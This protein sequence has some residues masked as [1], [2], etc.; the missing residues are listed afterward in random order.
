MAGLEDGELPRLERA[1]ALARMGR[2][3]VEPNPPVGCVLVG[4]TGV[5]GEGWH[6]AYG[7][8]HAEV[9]ALRIAGDAA[10]G[11]TAFVSLEPC[12]RRGKTPP[13][14]EALVA[15]G[16]RRVVFAIE[17]PHPRQRGAGAQ[18]LK[19]AGVQVVGP[20]PE[21]A[22]AAEALLV[23]FRAALARRRPWVHLKWAMS[24]D[25]RIAAEAGRGGAISGARARALTHEWRG[26]SDAVAV[27]VNTVLAD[28][29]DLR[30]R[31]E[32]GP[33]DGRPQPRRVVFDTSLR[34]PPGSAMVAKVEEAPVWIVTGEDADAMQE[35]RLTDLGCRVLRVP[36]AFDHLDIGQALVR[37]KAEGV[38]RLLV[39]GGAHVHGVLLRTRLA[40]Q[41]SAFVAPMV[42][43]DER[44]VLAVAGTRIRSVQDAIALD[45]VT[46][47]RLGDDLLLQG[48]VP[49]ATD[50][51]EEGPDDEDAD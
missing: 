36:S 30:C 34:M 48:F 33:P 32:G 25:G 26:R 42:L 46:W 21:V 7:G 4:P 17:D 50:V 45:D 6:K 43:G 44:G 9:E 14:T 12:S 23:Q 22:A 13:C 51:E 27:G 10:Q 40:D 5:V 3:S 24:L 29:P 49:G 39:E 18:A 15:A 16:V 37:L 20:V 28:D 38:E 35:R 11:A 8:P 31:L 19:K 1:I 2:C 47:K 41:V